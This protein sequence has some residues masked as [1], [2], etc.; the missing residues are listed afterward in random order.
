MTAVATA[1]RAR[2]SWV[3]V[4]GAVLVAVVVN[5]TIYVLG[6]AVGA[7]F[8]LTVAGDGRSTVDAATVAGFTAVPLLVG[9]GLAALLGPRW[10]WV[11][12][13]AFV[14][15]PALAVA[16]ILVMT[17]PADLDTASTITL[18]CMHLALVPVVVLALRAL[19]RP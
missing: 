12:P 7:T 15:G 4:S 11:Y 19:R 13:T 8:E 16:T 5:L 2:S 17:V 9:L 1:R 3:V 6:R 10:S 14:V 18:A